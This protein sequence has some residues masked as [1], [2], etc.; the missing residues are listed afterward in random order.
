MT[1]LIGASTSMSLRST[2]RLPSIF[3]SHGAPTFALEPGIA[4]P[5]LGALGRSLPKPAAVLV[6][7]AHWATPTVRVSVAPRPPTIHD[8]SGF[9]QALY[10]IQYPA[11]GHQELAHRTIS[12]L[13]A[14]G[15]VADPDPIRGLDHGA[16]VPLLYVYPNADVPVFQVSMP[17]RFDG[18]AAWMLGQALR[19][20]SSEHNV[21]IVGSGSLTHNLGEAVMGS[22]D[23]PPYVG[24]FVAWVRGAATSGDHS[25]LRKALAL[26]PHA[27][28]A[29]PTAEHFWP[30][31]VAAG[32]AVD[33][34][35]VAVIEGGIEHAVIAMESY[36]FGDF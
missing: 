1:E 26:A 34:A 36:V 13:R 28:R 7:S 19:R 14:A 20:L 6:I 32:A 12:M 16:W 5:K 8:F 24:E 21:L 10:D 30:L 2:N 18:E 33:Q 17:T 27:A 35:P 23:A 3:I 31:L 11:P 15:W 4:G 29:H 22:F 9:P 25:R